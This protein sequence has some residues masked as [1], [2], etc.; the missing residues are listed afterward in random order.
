MENNPDTPDSHTCM[1]V[2]ALA[3]QAL[4]FQPGESLPR[5]AENHLRSCPDCQA[6]YA[7]MVRADSELSAAL[8]I[9]RKSIR[10]PSAEQF[11]YIF[12]RVRE[13]PQTAWFLHQFRISVRRMLWLTLLA[14][15]FLIICALAWLLARLKGS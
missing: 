5:E 3:E 2:Q 4:I 6:K 7:E 11:D 1:G 8:Q 9:A 10:G 15:S 14:L 13:E 12:K